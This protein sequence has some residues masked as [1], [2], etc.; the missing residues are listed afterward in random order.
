M[1]LA[2]LLTTALA[3]CGTTDPGTGDDT[4]VNCDE[5]TG[6][7]QFV[8]GLEKVGN[9]NM[10]D[11]KMISGDPAP[12]ARNDNTWVIQLNQ[13]QGTT[14]GAAVAGASIVVT[15]FM[16]A[17][18]HG[19]GKSVLIT[20]MPTDGQYKLSPINLWM[21]GVWE[22]TIEVVSSPMGTDKVV[23]KFCIPS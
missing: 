15:P 5:I 11:Y 14:V 6:T 10:L 16:P 4:P 9:A 7:D 20:P 23:F 13:M 18:Q 8:V 12:P 17:H 2:I 22:T 1:R 21:P 19:A 3:A